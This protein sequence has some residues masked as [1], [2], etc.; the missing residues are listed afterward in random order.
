MLYNNKKSAIPGLLGCM[1][2]IAKSA[3][4][5]SLINQ[6]ITRLTAHINKL[7]SSQYEYVI[8]C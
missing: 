3:A 8:L 1:I 5:R 6:Y 7:T 2:G 4:S